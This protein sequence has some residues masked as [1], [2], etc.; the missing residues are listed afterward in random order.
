VAQLRREHERTDKDDSYNEDTDKEIEGHEDVVQTANS[1]VEVSHR[2]FDGQLL[3]MDVSA[4]VA[5]I[6]SECSTIVWT[7]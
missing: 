2:V 7:M 4:F 5:L 6:V 3:P 1:R